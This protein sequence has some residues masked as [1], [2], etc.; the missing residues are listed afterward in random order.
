MS[1]INE[2]V[3]WKRFK[4]KLFKNVTIFFN[5]KKHNKQLDIFP[6]HEHL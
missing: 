5:N 1:E 2:S 3:I 4:Q 6:L